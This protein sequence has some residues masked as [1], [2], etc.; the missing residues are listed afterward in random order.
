[1]YD[2]FYIIFILVT[3]DDVISDLSK[4]VCFYEL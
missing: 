2:F 4:K 3:S 1:M